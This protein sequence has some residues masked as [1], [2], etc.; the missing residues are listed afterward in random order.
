MGGAAPALEEAR[1]GTPG[2]SWTGIGSSCTAKTRRAAARVS[3]RSF[4]VLAMSETG[5]KVER[6]RR[7]V[8]GRS[9]RAILPS[10]TSQAPMASTARPPRPVIASIKDACD[11]WA[12]LNCV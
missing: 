7:A 11:A 5:E 12:F 10:S 4:T 2:P 3:I 8:S 9:G 6:A 1:A